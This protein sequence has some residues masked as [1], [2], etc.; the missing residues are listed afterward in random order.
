MLELLSGEHLFWGVCLV[1]L[2]AF[3]YAIYE[4]QR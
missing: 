1:A 3:L 4:A 2:A